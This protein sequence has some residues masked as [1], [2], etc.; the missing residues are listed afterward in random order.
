MTELEK[1]TKI[2]PA[3][4]FEHI[5]DPKVKD[6]EKLFKDVAEYYEFD[7]EQ[8]NKFK[9]GVSTEKFNNK[10][11]TKMFLELIINI[12]ENSKKPETGN[13]NDEMLYLKNKKI[14]K[15]LTF[16]LFDILSNFEYNDREVKII[17]IGKIL[18]SLHGR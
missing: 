6:I 8:Y 12:I 10:Q 13:K 9:E 16:N 14:V 5:F 3:T 1:R 18:Q 2:V 15:D 4:S 11:I 7:V 17:L